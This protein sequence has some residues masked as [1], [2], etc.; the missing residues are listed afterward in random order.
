MKKLIL[1]VIIVSTISLNAQRSVTWLFVSASGAYG[2]SFL[3]NE[4]TLND[5][6]IT[7][8]YFSPSYYYGGRFGAIFGENVGIVAGIN[9][10]FISQ[11]YTV[12][13]NNSSQNVNVGIGLFE[14]NFM[15]LL[16]SE[17]GFYFNIGP[18]FANVKSASLKITANTETQYDI[19]NKVSPKLNGISF[20]VGLK[21]LRTDNIELN[22]GLTGT[23]FFNSIISESAYFFPLNDRTFYNPSISDEKTYPV[24]IGV[25]LE[26]VYI[27]ARY[28]RASCGKN[29]IMIN[30]F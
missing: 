14:Y 26:L 25:N 4:A 29:R 2:T 15:L 17:T 16:Q 9:K 6:N 18:D 22:L 10:N 8:D 23:F 5:I 1:F 13:N 3:Y 11:G 21:P 19:L 20:K 24:Q 30:K 12:Q 28:G 7:Y 27:F